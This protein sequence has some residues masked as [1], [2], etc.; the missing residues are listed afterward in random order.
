MQDND[1]VMVKI[2]KKSFYFSKNNDGS[3]KRQLINKS[4][5]GGLMYSI[6]N[7]RI[8]ACFCS[9]SDL[10]KFDRKWMYQTLVERCDSVNPDEK[11][12]ISDFKLYKTK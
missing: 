12:S 2:Y 7:K 8:S 1:Y 11:H 9:P 10:P 6:K 4:L 5:V 3:T